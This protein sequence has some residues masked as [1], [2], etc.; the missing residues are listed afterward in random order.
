MTI[1]SI[2]NYWLLIPTFLML[3]L[4]FVIRN[5]YIKAGRSVKRIEA[6]SE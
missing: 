5:I 1:V 2:F 6:Q 4:F 3:I